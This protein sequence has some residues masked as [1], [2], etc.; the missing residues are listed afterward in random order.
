MIMNCPRLRMYCL[1]VVIILHLIG[2]IRSANSQPASAS[3]DY[4]ARIQPIFDNRCVAC[5][6]CYNAPC[7]LNLQSY[8]GLARGATKLNIYDRSRPKSVAPS[9]LDI[10]GHSVSDWRAKGF[11]DVVGGAEPARALLMQLLGLR[12]RHPTLQPKK[13]VEESNFCPADSDQGALVAQ[14]APE[15]GM[16]YGLPPLSQSEIA[17][18]SEWIASG[19]P[20]PS[21][22]SLA[23]RRAV[24]AQLHTEVRDWEAFL[25]GPTPREQLVARY[26][27][28]HLFL[29]HLHFTSETASRRPTFFRLVR[30]RTP[31]DAGVDEIATRRPN[32]DPGPGDF[33]YCLRRFDGSIVDKTHIPYGLSPEKLER[34]RRTF[35]EPRW[36]V[37]NLPGYS[38]ETAGNPFA[39]FAD[40]PVRAR[41]QFLLD[42][43]EYEISTFI[44]GS[45]VQRQR[46]GQFD[47]G[48][49]LRPLPET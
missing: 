45:S 13:P 39:T 3:E 28:E 42:D 21:G 44:K 9:R 34:V 7:Q 20:G 43:A 2:G 46:R 12:A 11:F 38:E 5:H 35:L 24:P 30:S 8:S 18:L 40:I 17:A 19:A 41:Y 15:I 4:T 1:L 37:K 23:S 14:S 25:N 29:A 32:D 16:P 33:H 6:S 47:P 10:D 49:V 36:D 22:A 48:T 27:Y 26:I 31:C